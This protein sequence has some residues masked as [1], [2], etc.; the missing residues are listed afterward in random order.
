MEAVVWQIYSQTNCDAEKFLVENSTS[1]NFVSVW[2]AYWFLPY[3][4][5]AR[6]QGVLSPWAN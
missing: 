5:I 2:S 6:K 3:E 1:A 4:D